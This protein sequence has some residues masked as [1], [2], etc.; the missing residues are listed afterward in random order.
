MTYWQ[1]WCL[2]PDAILTGVSAMGALIQ[3]VLSSMSSSDSCVTTFIIVSSAKRSIK[4][5]GVNAVT[6]NL[7][8]QG[9]ASYGEWY[10]HDNGTQAF[11]DIFTN[12]EIRLENLSVSS[13]YTTGRVSLENVTSSDL[14]KRTTWV[15]NEVEFEYHSRAGVCKT[16][17]TK[18]QLREGI[19]AQL[20]KM[21]NE[22]QRC[23]CWTYTGN[24]GWYGELKLM[25]IDNG[26]VNESA[27]PR[28]AMQ[29]K[30]LYTDY[31]CLLFLLSPPW[32][33]SIG[34]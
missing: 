26:D 11:D 16:R 10:L 7:G 31:T 15:H 12:G 24:H 32:S 4:V 25:K 17:L 22:K 23:S 34:V 1:N 29:I 33:S 18:A 14:R 9:Y 20:T 27:M 21:S 8:A 30:G 3:S 28:S 2:G 13:N 19:D 6:Y 5:V